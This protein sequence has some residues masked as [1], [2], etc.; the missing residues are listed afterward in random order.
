MAMYKAE[1]RGLELPGL[2][3]EAVHYMEAANGMTVRVPE[4]S[5]ENWSAAQSASPELT[6][7]EQRLRD[8]ILQDLYG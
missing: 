3:Q 4:S 6:E 1:P 7:A 5:L 8:R 2:E